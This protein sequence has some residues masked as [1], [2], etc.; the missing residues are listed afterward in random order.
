M[1]FDANVKDECKYGAW[2]GGSLF[3]SLPNFKDLKISH[4]IFK[5]SSWLETVKCLSFNIS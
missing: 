2:I 3:S 5:S 1:K 4:V